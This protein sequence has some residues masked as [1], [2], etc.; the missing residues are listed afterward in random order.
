V[1]RSTDE[2]KDDDSHRVE[3]IALITEILRD[4]LHGRRD[5]GRLER[6]KEGEGGDDGDDAPFLSIRPIARMLGIIC[7]ES[8]PQRK[9]LPRAYFLPMSPRRRSAV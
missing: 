1:E 9:Y 5:D 4:G 8:A 3:N 7:E 6:G 2:D